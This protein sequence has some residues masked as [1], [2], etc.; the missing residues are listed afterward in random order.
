LT[1]L[2]VPLR[3]VRQVPPQRREVNPYPDTLP[4]IIATWNPGS[5]ASFESFRSPRPGKTQP[6][7]RIQKLRTTLHRIRKSAAAAHPGARSRNAII[8]F[9]TFFAIEASAI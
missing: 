3:L 2:P 6:G 4:H 7:I 5:R 9:L 8:D 1:G